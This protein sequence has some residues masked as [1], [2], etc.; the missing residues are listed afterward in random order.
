MLQYL[1]A[2]E[3]IYLYSYNQLIYVFAEFGE[4]AKKNGMMVVINC[5]EENRRMSLCMEQHC[6]EEAFKKYAEDLGFTLQPAHTIADR[7]K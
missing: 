7:Y 6:G 4:C 5:R 3:L 1:F 2:F